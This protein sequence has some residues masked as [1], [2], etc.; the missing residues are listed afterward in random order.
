MNVNNSPTS[1]RVI[2]TTF[3]SMSEK[4]KVE[5]GTKRTKMQTTYERA[6]SN[7]TDPIRDLVSYNEIRGRIKGF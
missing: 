4:I 2:H 7:Q 1:K 3:Q 6:Y 5:R